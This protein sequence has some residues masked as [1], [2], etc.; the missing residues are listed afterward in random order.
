VKREF[1]QIRGILADEVA[2]SVP[3]DPYLSLRALT[4][5]SGL[6][7]RRLRELLDDPGHPLPCFRIGG[8]ILV[9]RSEYDAWAARYRQVGRDEV[10]R[11][12]CDVLSSLR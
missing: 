4:S 6:S 1:G 2:V 11:V 10:S 3:L 8:K 5:Y 9:R 7:I 12:V